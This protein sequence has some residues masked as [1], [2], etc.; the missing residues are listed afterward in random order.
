MKVT[1]W[2]EKLFNVL[3]DPI[4][5]SID[6]RKI[7]SRLNYYYQR[8]DTQ[9]LVVAG[10]IGDVKNN[11]QLLADLGMQALLSIYC[12]KGKDFDQVFFKKELKDLGCHRFFAT[13]VFTQLEIWRNALPE[14]ITD[15]EMKGQ[16]STYRS[17]P[18]SEMLLA[19]R[20]VLL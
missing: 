8:L 9:D 5:E 16:W 6:E 7:E 18:E 10:R 15:D 3:V 4:K 11:F 13:K 1:R 2:E 12:A 14:D 17:L 19:Q 20:Y